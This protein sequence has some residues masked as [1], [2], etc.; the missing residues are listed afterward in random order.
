MGFK[1]PE[2]LDVK[3]P[4]P[5]FD[6][7]ISPEADKQTTAEK[8]VID[9]QNILPPMMKKEPRGA[10]PNP[11]HDFYDAKSNFIFVKVKDPYVTH[12]LFL[13]LF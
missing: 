13:E 1:R 4:G 5:P 3:K 11:S 8:R 6:S 2:R 12:V 7:Q 9:A 10:H